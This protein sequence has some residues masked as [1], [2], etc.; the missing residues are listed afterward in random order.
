MFR[1]IVMILTNFAC[2]VAES[3]GYLNQ[4]EEEIQK[5]TETQE[6][7]YNQVQDL[8][9]KVKEE[10]ADLEDLKEEFSDV[11]TKINNFQAEKEELNKENICLENELMKT[12]EALKKIKLDNKPILQRKEQL[13]HDLKQM[14]A[15]ICEDSTLQDMIKDT[16]NKVQQ[17]LEHIKKL[18]ED[19]KIEKEKVR[20]NES[21]V[22]KIRNCVENLNKLKLSKSQEKQLNGKIKEL[23]N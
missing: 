3:V 5:Q 16:K 4:Y 19:V 8:E 10:R 6:K 12:D 1:K 15:E 13:Q 22:E 11:P 21:D 23:E 20:E 14:E 18:E 9:V 2:H 7:L 17:Y